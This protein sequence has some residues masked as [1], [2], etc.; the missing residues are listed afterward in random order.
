MSGKL[1]IRVVKIEGV[2]AKTIDQMVEEVRKGCG[3]FNR[4]NSW[5]SI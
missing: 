4:N 2:N 1:N 5:N 3:I